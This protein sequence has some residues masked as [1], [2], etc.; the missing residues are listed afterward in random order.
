M[1]AAG[2]RAAGPVW[3]QPRGIPAASLPR[4]LRRLLSLGVC[5]VVL[6]SHRTHL[7]RWR[8]TMTRSQEFVEAADLVFATDSGGRFPAH[9]LLLARCCSCFSGSLDLPPA[10]AAAAGSKRKLSEDVD[11][12]QGK[13][14]LTYTVGVS[15]EVRNWYILWRW[16]GLEAGLEAA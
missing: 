10:A 14:C 13:A 5:G 7:P 11:S 6:V 15:S 9:R 3:R 2:I 12:A 1:G 4:P 8:A 16:W